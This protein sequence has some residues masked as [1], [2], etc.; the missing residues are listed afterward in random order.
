MR[1]PE[2]IAD[3]PLDLFVQKLPENVRLMDARFEEIASVFSAGGV[4]D[5][6]RLPESVEACRKFAK[7]FVELNDFLE[8]P[9]CKVSLGG[10]RNTPSPMTMDPWRLCGRSSM[11]GHI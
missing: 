11:N 6:M 10:G 5:F 7:L 2:N 4:E 8:S 1:F 3:K 9:K